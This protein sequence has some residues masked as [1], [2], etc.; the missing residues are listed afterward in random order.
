MIETYELDSPT[1]F[2]EQ[3]YLQDTKKFG[4]YMGKE[5]ER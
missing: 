5:M 1:G 2:I 4:I 3:T